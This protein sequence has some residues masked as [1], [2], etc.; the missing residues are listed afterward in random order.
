MIK[1]AEERLG[2]GKQDCDLTLFLS[3]M[4]DLSFEESMERQKALPPGPEYDTVRF[5]LGLNR[6]KK[7]M[8]AYFVSPEYQ[9]TRLKRAD[10]NV[11]KIFED[12]FKDKKNDQV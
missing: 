4:Q 10:R 1:M 6:V 3:N 2:T 5:I 9:R 7:V 12:T 11:D 8:T